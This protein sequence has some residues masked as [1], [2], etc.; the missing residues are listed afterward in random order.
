MYV[1]NIYTHFQISGSDDFT[2]FLWSPQV[3]KVALT[4]MVGH[5]QLINHIAFSPDGRYI[6]SGSFDKKVKLW[7]GKT[8]R[9]LSTCTGHVSYSFLPFVYSYIL[10]YIHSHIHILE[11]ILTFL[12]YTT[13]YLYACILML[14]VCVSV[15][16]FLG[17]V[18]ISGELVSR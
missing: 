17:G 1:L 12:V 10:T 2:M 15:N 4:R 6:A 7:C 8:G 13:V 3:D 18:G 5:Q 16:M 11:Y 9:F 14:I